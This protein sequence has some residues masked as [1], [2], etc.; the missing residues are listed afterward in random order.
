MKDC[1]A[2]LQVCINGLCTGSICQKY[3]MTQCY[4]QGDLTSSN[5]DKAVLCHLACQGNRTNN[6]CVDSAQISGL[7]D[8]LHNRSGFILQPGS[9]CSSSRG[10]CDVFSKCRAYDGNAVLSGLLNTLTNPL[11]FTNIK[12]W[13]TNY[14]WAILLIG[15]VV[16]TLICVFVWLCSIH[17]PTS[18]PNQKSTFKQNKKVKQP[19]KRNQNT[20]NQAIE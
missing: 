19:I 5:V 2:G 11:I 10:Y 13:A 4:L 12:I 16:I 7:Y 6:S 15:I 17:V 20:R 3:D 1:N 14:W 8:Y 18:N 9:A